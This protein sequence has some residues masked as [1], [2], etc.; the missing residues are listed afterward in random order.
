MK[1]LNY[2]PWLPRDREKSQI[3]VSQALNPGVKGDWTGL[4]GHNHLLI[5][6]VKIYSEYEESWNQIRNIN[7]SIELILLNA[8]KSFKDAIFDLN[9]LF[10][11]LTVK[12]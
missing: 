4:W 2:Y 9:V 12:S 10:L 1:L 3:Q 8:L 5:V 7:V 11:T 6:K